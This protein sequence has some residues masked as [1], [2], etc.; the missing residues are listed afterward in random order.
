MHSAG[1]RVGVGVFVIRRSDGHILVGKRKGSHGEGTYQLPGGH[2]EFNESFESCALREVLEETGL[3]INNITFGTA[4]NDPM[5]KDGKHYVTIFMK[6]ECVDDV[7]SP[8]LL[9]PEKCEFWMF[10]PFEELVTMRPLFQPLI[11]LV[12]TRSRFHPLE[13]SRLV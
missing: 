1:P 9:E 8:K 13:Q 4:T 12:Q 2:L 3:C 11:T 10:M 7:P 6:G 5:P